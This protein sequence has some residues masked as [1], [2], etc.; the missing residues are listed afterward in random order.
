MYCILAYMV[1]HTHLKHSFNNRIYS[2]TE[3][4]RK[5]N[6]AIQRMRYMAVEHNW[7]RIPGSRTREGWS[8][9]QDCRCARRCWTA[10]R[11]CRLARWESPLRSGLS[12]TPSHIAWVDISWIFS[13]SRWCKLI[14]SSIIYGWSM[15]IKRSDLSTQTTG[16][17]FW[18]KG[19]LVLVAHGIVNQSV[20]QPVPTWRKK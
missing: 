8:S 16:V 10:W 11:S 19:S 20:E 1:I 4:Q 13:C 18:A 6:K 15:V 14:S 7:G 2:W 17:P 9:P 12:W 5:V 3:C